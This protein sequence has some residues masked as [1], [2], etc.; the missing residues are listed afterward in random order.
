MKKSF[1]R[2]SRFKTPRPPRQARK[3]RRAPPGSPPGTLAHDPSAHSPVIR[4]IAYGPDSM[5]EQDITDVDD[6]QGFLKGWPVTWVNVD[7]LA[8]QKIIRHL[9]KIFDIHDL[10]LEDI[11]NLHQRPKVEEYDDHIFIVTKMG[12]IQ[13][14]AAHEQVSL[15]LGKNYV[16]TFQEC[17]GDAFEPVRERLHSQRG[18]IRKA[19]ADYLAYALIDAVIDGYFPILEHYGDLVEDAED[20]VL[21]NPGID[22]VTHLHS[23]RRDLFNLRRAIWPQRDMINVLIRD[24]SPLISES[25]HV[26]LRDCY[27]HTVQLLDLTETY[28]E[29]TAGLFELYLSSVSTK[30]N[31]VMKFLTLI[32]TV[33]IPLGFIAGLYG[34]N[35]D[36]KA[37]PWNMP[38]LGWAWGYPFALALMSAVGLGLVYLFYRRGWLGTRRIHQKD[39][40]NSDGVSG[41]A[42]G[43]QL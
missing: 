42:D 15:F 26:Y 39:P 23:L 7:G 3:K 32:A 1:P 6:L 43:P 27:D 41:P 24:S 31:E 16:L 28:R 14:P 40:L 21:L 10:A 13:A 20:A 18:E 12:S 38:E 22:L 35:F 19:G 8:D 33:F 37:S 36:P 2:A 17:P 4:A 9:G 25:T 34:M 11:V 5:E 30:M 29:I